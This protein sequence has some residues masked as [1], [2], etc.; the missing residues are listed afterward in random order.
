MSEKPLVSARIV[1]RYSTGR[2]VR[3]AGIVL[4][5]AGR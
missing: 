2:E 1:K 3:S 4:P 5:P